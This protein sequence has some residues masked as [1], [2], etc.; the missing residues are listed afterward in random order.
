MGL[1]LLFGCVV[2]WIWTRSAFRGSA[3]AL[4]AI[5]AVGVH[6]PGNSRR[7]F[8]APLVKPIDITKTVE[9][10]VVNWLARNRPGERAM[11]SGDPEYI[12]NLYTDNPQLSAGHEPTAP[13]WMQRVAVFIVYTGMNAGEHDAED[14]IFWLKAYGVHTIYVPGPA[15]REH[16]H[17][18][19]N[20][21]KFDGVLPVLWHDEDDTIYAVPQR[22]GSLAHVMPRE[23]LVTRPA[24]PWSRSRPR[25]RLRRRARRCVAASRAS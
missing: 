5:L 22:S 16:Y 17:P 1:A 2:R 10:K 9:Y 25:T 23:A 24:H 4:V 13:N 6:A 20:P 21:H 12:F 8:A 7:R 15:S 3:I 19:V 14:S 18:I 11:V